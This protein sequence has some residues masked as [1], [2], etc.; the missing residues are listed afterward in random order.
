MPSPVLIKACL[1]GGRPADAH[2]ALPMTAEQLAEAA[3]AATAAGAAAVHV[4]PRDAEG[5][6]SHAAGVIGDAVSAIRQACPGLPIG[7]TTILRITNDPAERLR[8]VQAWKV[9]PDF[10]SVNWFEPGAPELA[11]L[12]ISMGV[13]VEAGLATVADA[14]AFAAYASASRCLRILVEVRE[15]DGVDAVTLASRMDSVL[16]AAGLSVPRLHHGFG[17]DTWRVIAAG[18]DRGRDV[19]IGLEDVLTLPDGST[20]KDNA[21]LVSTAVALALRHDREPTRYF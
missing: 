20:A 10:A 11:G 1:N 2:P 6:Q 9:L 15:R 16:D 8:Q 19:R 13:G 7:V 5:R 17:A 18:F 12:L 14:R 4:H 3:V 21:D